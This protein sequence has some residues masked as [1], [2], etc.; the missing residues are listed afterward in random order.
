MVA[1]RME[2]RGGMFKGILQKYTQGKTN[3]DWVRA[4]FESTEGSKRMT[5]EEFKERGY[6]VVPTKEGWE[7]ETPGL[8]GFNDDPENNRLLTPTGK[9]E[10]YSSA[11]AENFPDDEER[12]PLP[13]WVEESDEH[14]DR[15]T[16]SRA[17]DY[18][19]LLVSNHPRWRVHAQ[20]DDVT[21]FRE[22][23]TCKIK[24]PDGYAYEPIWVNPIDAGKLGIKHHDIL[25]LF[26]ERGGVLGA[27]YITERIMPGVLSQDHGA[28][29]DPIITGYGVGLDRGGANN[30]ICPSAVTSKNSP[31]MV[32]SGFLVNIEKADVLELARQ[33]PGAFARDYDPDCGIVLSSRIQK[34]D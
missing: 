1:E 4:G 2:E 5:Y 3:D 33:H 22:I 21:W 16:S 23:E 24:G 6:Y 30:L 31:G 7:D 17:K 29:V 26:N 25:R 20:H 12:P 11:L 8:Y 15:I 13:R 27:A 32:T 18:P 10:Y 34:E 9:L 28:R 19:F 14:K